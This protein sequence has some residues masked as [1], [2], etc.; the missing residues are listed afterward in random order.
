M[1]LFSLVEQ[2]DIGF[3]DFVRKNPD[4]FDFTE[5]RRIPFQLVIVPLLQYTET[6]KFNM[7][8]WIH[9]HMDT[10]TH[11]HMDTWTHGHMDTWTHGHM[12]IWTHGHMD[13]WTHGHMD[14]WTYGHMDIWTH[15][16]MD[17][18]TRTFWIWE[19]AKLQTHGFGVSY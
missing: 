4:R 6:P 12:D 17:T 5:L 8:T 11:G 7:D 2:N 10:W 19:D 14:T 13:I 16:H 9:G 15:G 18:W 1:H 3:P